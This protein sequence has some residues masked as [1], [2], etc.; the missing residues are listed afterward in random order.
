MENRFDETTWGKGLRIPDL[1]NELPHIDEEDPEFMY[2]L[3]YRAKEVCDT[4]GGEVSGIGLLRAARR[5]SQTEFRD[6]FRYSEHKHNPARYQLGLSLLEPG[7]EV[8][9]Y[10]PRIAQRLG[11]NA[12]REFKPLWEYVDPDFMTR[13]DFV[14]WNVAS[15]ILDDLPELEEELRTMDSKPQLKLYQTQNTHGLT[16]EILGNSIQ[17]GL[18]A[19]IDEHD[20]PNAQQFDGNLGPRIINTTDKWIIEERPD[21]TRIE[22]YDRFDT[23]Q[24]YLYGN[25]LGSALSQIHDTGYSYNSNLHDQVY[26]DPKN[27]KIKITNWCQARQNGETESDIEMA[28][29]IL[30]QRYIRSIGQDNGEY[31]GL[32]SFGTQPFIQAQKGFYDGYNKKIQLPFSEKIG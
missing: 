4:D 9:R 6:S 19:I 26:I 30:H 21:L 11:V 25:I 27:N 28:K 8:M 29:K 32:S 31:S 17:I 10:L 5:L 3:F 12:D 14:H 18:R 7:V 16:A 20:L 24:P 23:R 13:L 22:L 15:Q 2:E 1:F